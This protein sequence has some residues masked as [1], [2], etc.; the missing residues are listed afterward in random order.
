MSTTVCRLIGHGTLDG[1]LDAEGR[2]NLWPRSAL[3]KQNIRQ[4][5]GA[6]LQPPG[7]LA[8]ACLVAHIAQLA[9]YALLVHLDS[10]SGCGYRVKPMSPTQRS[11]AHLRDQGY[12]V[13]IVEHWNPHARIRQDLFGWIDLLA[14][15]DTE[16]L[17]V[18]T[19]ASAVADRVK[20]ITDSASLSAVRKAGWRIL[21][22]G[23]RKNAAGRYVL[24]EVDLS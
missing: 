7:R 4:I 18:Q 19:T 9:E 20:K 15:R 12:L 14:L 5:R 2:E 8:Q 21:V 1:A 13:A 10:V 22:H 11:L 23:W 16:T 6:N 17:A 24:R 3:A